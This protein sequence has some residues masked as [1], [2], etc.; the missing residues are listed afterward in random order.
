LSQID[1]AAVNLDGIAPHAGATFPNPLLGAWDY[2]TEAGATF[3]L[4]KWDNLT[5]SDYPA[6]PDGNGNFASNKTYRAVIKVTPAAGYTLTGLDIPAIKIEGIPA[7]L[8]GGTTDEIFADF[9]TESLINTGLLTLFNDPSE[10]AAWPVAGEPASAFAVLETAEFTGT[11]LSWDPALIAG[12]FAAGTGYGLQLQ[13]TPKAGYTL[14]GLTTAAVNTYATGTYDAA[15]DIITVAQ[16]GDATNPAIGAIS[17]EADTPVALALPIT[18]NNNGGGA[19]T[20][21]R[22]DLD[23]LGADLDAGAFKFDTEYIANVTI[24]AAANFTTFGKV[25]AD[26]AG[27]GSYTI[28]DFAIANGNGDITFKVKYAKTDKQLSPVTLTGIQP[29]AGVAL[30]PNGYNWNWTDAVYTLVGWQLA[31]G[32]TAVPDGTIAS[33]SATYRALIKVEP[34]DGYTLIGSHGLGIDVASTVDGVNAIGS[35]EDPVTGEILLLT[36]LQTELLINTSYLTLTNNADLTPSYPVAGEL[37]SAFSAY[38]AVAASFPGNPESFDATIVSWNPVLPADGKF[39]PATVYSVVLDIAPKAGYSTY[40][41]NDSYWTA[42]GFTGVTTWD[43]AT[44]QATVTFGA[45]KTTITGKSFDYKLPI[46]TVIAANVTPWYEAPI[47]FDLTWDNDQHGNAFD[48]NTTYSAIV[49]VRADGLS[50][51]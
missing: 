36:D 10:V 2:T 32:Y 24:R 7:A 49:K 14:Y 28:E 25:A 27:D 40:G 31:P 43:A 45:T 11:I 9:T 48:F 19:G 22:F 29:T 34:K 35:Y 39:A 26:F 30:A 8:Y 47:E 50:T 5:D 18:I 44:N 1:A 16:L 20:H 51:T 23:W 37:A 13:L 12:N 38:D 33:A 21:L 15:T 4:I 41:L 42:N 17:F 46:A 3:E 6:V